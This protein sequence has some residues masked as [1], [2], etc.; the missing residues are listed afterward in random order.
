MTSEPATEKQ[1]LSDSLFHM[2]RC[3][4]AII[5]ADGVYHQTERKFLDKAIMALENAYVVTLEHRK[6]FADDLRHPQNLDDLLPK[7]TEPLH[8]VLLPYF[9]DYISLLDGQAGQSEKA[10]VKKIRDQLDTPDLRPLIAEVQQS[11]ATKKA[12]STR[13]FQLVDFLLERLGI[14]RLE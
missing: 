9:C 13:H 7:V 5:M 8:R 2:W 3:L 4:V 6:T 11:L 1:P 14:G 12:E 10:F